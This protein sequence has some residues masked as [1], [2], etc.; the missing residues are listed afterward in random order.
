[1]TKYYKKYIIK[2]KLGTIPNL[3]KFMNHY[4]KQRKIILEILNN[5]CHPTAEELYSEINK[6]KPTIS[7][8]T[9][10]RNI[11]ILLKN[12][13]IKKIK[14]LN[15]P[16][17]FDANTKEH[18]HIICENCDRVLDFIYDFEQEELKKIIKQQTGT[19]I[20]INSITLYGICEECKSKKKED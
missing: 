7:R 5:L 18:Y 1:M 15:G 16:D 19:S 2:L 13:E 11:G 9:V 8:S 6:R 17:R 20:N 4:S 12:E 3:E 10:Y 14:I